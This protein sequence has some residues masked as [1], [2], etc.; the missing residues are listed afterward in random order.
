MKPLKSRLRIIAVGKEPSISFYI[1]SQEESPFSTA[2][3]AAS[4]VATKLTSA[5]MSYAQSWWKNDQLEVLKKEN[6]EKPIPLSYKWTIND[7]QRHILSIIRD[8]SGRLA[9]TTDGFGRVLL[10]D[11]IQSLVIRMWKGYRDAQ[12]GLIQ[13]KDRSKNSSEN[14]FPPLMVVI[15]GARR[16][17]LEVWRLKNGNREMMMN[18]GKGCKLLTTQTPLGTTIGKYQYS[19]C[20]LLNPN[21][22]IQEITATQ[23]NTPKNIT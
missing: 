1:T 11:A 21:G 19:R 15:Y 17:I 10:V 14:S 8:P 3:A 18:V 13:W 2:V 7:T 23:I 12:I 20:Y 4:S 16:G 9:A 22:L 6:I 5:V